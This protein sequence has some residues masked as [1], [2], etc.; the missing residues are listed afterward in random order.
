[1]SPRPADRKWPWYFGIKQCKRLNSSLTSF[2]EVSWASLFGIELTLLSSKQP[3]D[4][5]TILDDEG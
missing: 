1:M 3:R 4:L 5:E 2:H